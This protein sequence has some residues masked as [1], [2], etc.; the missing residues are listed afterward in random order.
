MSLALRGREFRVPLRFDLH[1]AE[2]R[3]KLKRAKG[4]LVPDV[5]LVRPC[6]SLYVCV[7]TEEEGCWLVLLGPIAVLLLTSIFH[8]CGFQ[9]KAVC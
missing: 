4:H 1:L 6:V 9:T 3:S 8:I 7:L 2:V 5:V